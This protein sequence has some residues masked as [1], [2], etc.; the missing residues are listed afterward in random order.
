MPRFAFPLPGRSKKH[1]PPPA[2]TQHM[3]KAHKVLGSTYISIDSTKSW[4]GT[5]NSGLSVSVTESTAPTSHGSGVTYRGGSGR[6]DNAPRDWDDE[7]SVLPRRIMVDEPSDDSDENET[8]PTRVLRGHPSS[9]TIKSW[10]D[11]SKQ[12]LSVTQQTSASAM[13]KGMPSKA[14]RLLDVDNNHSGPKNRKKP[15]RLDLTRLKGDHHSA[16]DWEG[17]VLGNGY[18]NQSP[19]SITPKTSSTMGTMGRYRQKLQSKST[20]ED[21]RRQP[22]EASPQPSPSSSERVSPRRPPNM[23]ELPNLYKHYEQTS[24]ALIMD[25]DLAAAAGEGRHQEPLLDQPEKISIDMAALPTRGIAQ[26]HRL[27]SPVTPDDELPSPLRSHP[28]TPIQAPSPQVIHIPAL[29]KQEQLSPTDCSASISSRHTR[30]SKAS[31]R[32]EKS[33]QTADF[34]DRSVLM[35]SS[36]SEDED[37]GKIYTEL[38]VPTKR[39]TPSIGSRPTSDVF[40]SNSIHSAARSLSTGVIP[41]AEEAANRQSNQTV[42]RTSTAPAGHLAIPS[43]ASTTSTL[44]TVSSTD[45]NAKSHWESTLH[46][47][48]PSILSVASGSS[49]GTA[50]SLHGADGYSY[51]EAR[52]V[53]IRPALAPARG[54]GVEDGHAWNSNWDHNHPDTVVRQS[55]ALIPYEEEPSAVAGGLTIITE[56]L[57]REAV[58]S[59]IESSPQSGEMPVTTEELLMGLTRQEQILIKGLRRRRESMRKAG[60]QRTGSKPVKGHQSQISEATIT[61]ESFNFSFP[62]PP[63]N[64]HVPRRSSSAFPTMITIPG[65]KSSIAG[66]TK[67]TAT[68]SPSFVLS[69]PPPHL[70]SPPRHSSRQGTRLS[71]HEQ[72]LLYL[73]H[74]GGPA[75]AI[76]EGMMSPDTETF[77]VDGPLGLAWPRESLSPPQYRKS[78]RRQRSNIETSVTSSRE[79]S[80]IRGRRGVSPAF[81]DLPPPFPPPTRELPATPT[82]RTPEEDEGVPRPDSPLSFAFP[83]VPEKRRTQMARLSAFGPSNWNCPSDWDD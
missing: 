45:S 35:L 18:V 58:S 73:D 38:S 5:T 72:M 42:R 61:E 17:P 52:V 23:T 34:I 1:A 62:K 16:K 78:V 12:P 64:K 77:G 7:S 22:T 43:R 47:S 51:E 54:R 76:K 30:T 40:D 71:K 59:Y 67:S 8:D 33:F 4:D 66:S 65:S 81:E 70:S 80:P 48:T 50:K 49:R 75:L 27:T 25:Q 53:E 57:S 9:S 2:S 6:A 10:Y 21:L 55:R 44:A 82:P 26:D 41:R 37:D 32:T 68:D 11:K 20:K 69:P 60:N 28:T 56:H 19:A 13:A 29:V 24:F 79:F 46:S 74:P 39:A 3:T 36:D 83:S 15:S 63:K 31:K 14:Q